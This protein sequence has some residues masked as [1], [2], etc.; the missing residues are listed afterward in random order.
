MSNYFKSL[1]KTLCCGCRACEQ[2]CPI[3]CIEM[4]VDKEGFIY[5][6]IENDKCISCKMC[7]KVCPIKDDGYKNKD[8]YKTPKSYGAYNRNDNIIDESTSGGAFSAIIDSFFEDE[9]IVFGAAFDENLVVKHSF[10]KDKKSIAKFRGSKYVQS[11]LGTSYIQIKEFLKDNK[12]VLFSGTPC[13]VAGL[14]SFLQKDYDNLLCVDI[15][16]H[17]VPSPK[18]FEM[19]KNYLSNKYNSKITQI[20]F[21]DKSIKGWDTP[22]MS[23]QFYNGK[24]LS[25]IGFD[26]LFTMGFY[27]KLYQRPVCHECPFTQVD[28][29]SDIT[30][31]DFWGVEEINPKFK[32]NKGT[33]LILINSDK[34][35][36][37]YSNLDKN[38]ILEEVDLSSVI[39]FNPQL[40]KPTSPSAKRKDFMRDLENGKDFNELRKIYLKKR[41]LIKRLASRVLNKD[42]KD[43]IKKIIKR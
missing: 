16:C 4:K 12:K 9:I 29:V 30:I 33:S 25:T 18:V 34:G 28:R 10:V 23:I 26:D 3:N 8:A 21:R 20:N 36:K 7:E 5:P 42:M 41:P 31:A 32:N 2:V 11:D 40:A 43:K 24:K 15:V 35:K 6:E 38:L 1:D 37:L 27:K 19:Y 17:G 39:N 13:Q 22:Y 14:K